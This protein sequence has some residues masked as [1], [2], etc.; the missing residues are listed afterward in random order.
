MINLEICP[1]FQNLARTDRCACDKS[2]GDEDAGKDFKACGAAGRVD[3]AMGLADWRW[4][5]E[6]AEEAGERVLSF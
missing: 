1:K 4:D 3:H 2:L 5:S 6:V